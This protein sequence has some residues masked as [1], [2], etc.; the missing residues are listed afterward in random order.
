MPVQNFPIKD[1]TVEAI[2][3]QGALHMELRRLCEAFFSAEEHG[4]FLLELTV[5]TTANVSSECVAR[6]VYRTLAR[7]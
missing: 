2:S 5:E 3:P 7:Q 1:A 4:A 6:G